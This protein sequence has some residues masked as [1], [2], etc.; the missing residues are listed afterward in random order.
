MSR[1]SRFGVTAPRKSAVGAVLRGFL[2][3]CLGIWALHQEA[4]AQSAATGNRAVAGATRILDRARAEAATSC[5]Q[6]SDVLVRIL[7]ER[8]LTVGL[9][10]YYPGF[11]VRDDHGAFTGFEPDIARRIAAFLGVDLVTYAVNTRTRIPVLAEGRADLV[12]ATMGHTVLRDPEA[13]FIRPHYYISQTAVVGPKANPVANWGDL[14]GRTACLPLGSSTNL[15]FVQNHVRILTFDRPEQLLDALRFNQCTFISHDDTFFAELLADHAW[16]AQYGI[17]FRFSP[18]PWGMAVAR[19]RTAQW[20]SLLDALSFAFHA[21]GVFIELAKGHQLDL[22]FLES[23]RE[24]LSATACL[25]ADGEPAKACFMPPFDNT[26]ATDTSEIALYAIWIERM[27]AD[28]FGVTV[29]LSLFK[30]Q[31]TVGLLRESVVYSLALIVG[32]Q[33]STLAFALGFGWLMVS[34]FSPIRRGVGALTT[35]WQVTPLPLLMFFVYV[36]AGGIAQYSGIVALIAAI[37]AIGLYN[38]SNAARAVEEAHR[39]L[40]RRDVLTGSSG[41]PGNRRSFVRTISLASVQL[42]SFL[43]NAAKGSPAAGMIGVPEFLNVLTDLTANSRDRV[44]VNV[45]LLVF[46]MTLVL[47][48]IRLLAFARTRFVLATGRR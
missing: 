31:S 40:L 39:T 46:Y 22:S 9:R 7:C 4:R 34:G 12:I 35:V 27:M 6:P 3:L 5:S 48:V 21:N 19:E 11:A 20:A 10:T 32:T 41:D 23:E 43:I 47:V 13:R 8:R 26:A 44:T 16:S 45:I 2:V 1:C 28:R 42:V 33:L 36:V 38:G 17:K 30:H 24:K 18:L 29:D 15:T 25:A 37:F 14:A